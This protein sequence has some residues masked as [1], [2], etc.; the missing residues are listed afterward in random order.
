MNDVS[1]IPFFTLYGET[2]ALPDMVHVEPISARSAPNNWNIRA[3]RHADLR[4]VFLIED[5]NVAISLDGET[6]TVAPD[7]FAFVPAKVVHA[8]RLD[9]GTRGMVLSFSAQSLGAAG[10]AAQRVEQALARPF[11]GPVTDDL[12]TLAQSLTNAVNSTGPYRL[13]K[14]IG[15][16]NAL[17]AELAE[18][19][20][21]SA[22]RP[23][24]LPLQRLERLA[25]LVRQHMEEGWSVA[26]Y[27][28]ALAV[29]S[30]HLSR[31]C[32]A[33]TGTGAQAH[34]ESLIMDEACRHLAYTDLPVA[35]IGYRTGFFD[36]SYF[37]KRF[38]A[39]HGVSPRAYRQQFETADPDQ[40]TADRL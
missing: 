11:S 4:Q 12:K 17:L 24:T 36:P 19:G 30:G 20:T 32:R 33:A 5:G 26:D 27:A 2:D 16:V 25:Q 15:L 21:N 34:I 28:A 31:I 7:A 37:S 23:A 14:I 39:L 38:R 1:P 3:H 6:V 10:P 8:L 29:S 35:E 40:D 9:P 18:I 22:N 13:Q